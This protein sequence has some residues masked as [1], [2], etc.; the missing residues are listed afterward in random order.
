MEGVSEEVWRRFQ[1]L[2]GRVFHTIKNVGGTNYMHRYRIGTDGKLILEE[3]LL[4][5]YLTGKEVQNILK[6]AG[7]EV[8]F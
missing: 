5:A 8:W 1:D 7:N 6:Q 3:K 2:Q 4:G